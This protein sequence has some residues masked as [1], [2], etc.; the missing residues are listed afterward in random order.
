[1]PEPPIAGRPYQ[2]WHCWRGGVVYRA[3][4]P[5]AW[6]AWVAA[7]E[8]R[9][10]ARERRAIAALAAVGG[11]TL[12]APARAVVRRALGNLADLA[13]LQA[14]DA[15]DWTPADWRGLAHALREALP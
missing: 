5:A 12:G 9:G 8:A 3:R 7:Q 4:T 1:M 13:M 14:D 11:D 6:V 2:A 10:A 15:L